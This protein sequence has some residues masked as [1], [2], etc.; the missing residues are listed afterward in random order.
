LIRT[1]AYDGAP[2]GRRLSAHRALAEVYRERHD[3]CRH[4]WHL[5]SAAT[6]PDETVAATLERAA[7]LGDAAG[8]LRSSAAIYEHA[9][10]LTADPAPRGRRLTAAARA[11]ADA[12]QLTRAAAL[13]DRA[14]ADVRG[15]RELADIALVRATVLDEQDRPRHAHRLLADTARSVVASDP[16]LAGLLLFRAA[17]AAAK[18]G[19]LA[20]LDRTAARATAFDVPKAARVRAVATVFAGQNALASTGADA[21]TGA[22]RD[23]LDAMAECDGLLDMV[24]LGWWQLQLGDLDAA[25]DTATG[26]ERQYRER[27]AIGLLAGVLPLL[28][29][30]QLMLGRHREALATATEGLRI[31]A[32]TGQHRYA[33]YLSTVL[34]QL[35]AIEGDER[36]CIELTTEPLARGVAPGNVHASGALSLLD[37]GLGRYEAALSRLTAV[38]AGPNLQGVLASLPDLV[39]AALRTE[40]PDLATQANSWYQNWAGRLHQPWAEATALRCRALLAQ[41]ASAG[42]LYARA[43]ALH[44]RGGPPFERARSELLYG[45]WL[46]RAR[47]GTDAR[48]QLRPALETFTRLEARPWAERTRTELRATGER[49]RPPGPARNLDLADRLT[50]QELQVVRLASQGMSNRDIGAR[51]FLS[52]RTVGYHLYKAYPKLGVASRGE[53]AAITGAA[54]TPSPA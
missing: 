28:A 1:A 6:G 42:D 18:A 23:L 27:G 16:E 2:L 11:A 12:G 14:A 33:I 50:P 45:E 43:V 40:H 51:L 35:A 52:P 4:A 29:R 25:H 20:A 24:D 5:S 30:T 44:R 3:S 13:A 15:P 10:D 19:D 7:R 46:R 49:V 17:R 21:A 9:A 31:A 47:R 8:G 54:A 22:L 38:V 53:L 48:A 39:E 36:R 37:L 32:D 26:L 41:D 34:A